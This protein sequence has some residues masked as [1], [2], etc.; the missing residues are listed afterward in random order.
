[1]TIREVNGDGPPAADPAGAWSP[2]SASDVSRM[3]RGAAFP[4]WMAGGWAIDLFVGRQT[5]RHADTDVL[6]LRR[7]QL[8][9][10]SL[11]A[12]GAGWELYAADP[13][14]VLRAWRRGE[15][16]PRLLQTTHSP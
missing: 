2:L 1:M 7:D 3:F 9:A 12:A 13:P 8:A 15:W 4:W 16:L 5:R 11:L 10:Q 6:V 14:G